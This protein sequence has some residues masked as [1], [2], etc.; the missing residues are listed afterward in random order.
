M[1]KKIIAAGLVC[2]MLVSSMTGCGFLVTNPNRN[3]LIHETDAPAIDDAKG[4]SGQ[5][6]SNL[7]TPAEEDQTD[8]S[9]RHLASAAYPEAILKVSSEE[10]FNSN[11]IFD[12]KAFEEDE[13]AWNEMWKEQRTLSEGLQDQMRDFYLT[14][15][16]FLQNNDGE[17][18]VCSPLSVYI[19]LAMLAE[20]AEG[21]T[22]AEI[23]QAIGA[24]SMEEARDLA[25]RLWR[26]NYVD[27]GE[28]LTDIASSLWLRKGLAVREDVLKT[29]AES[30]FAD[31][32]EGDPEDP[33]Y[34]KALQD[35]LNEKT[36]GLLQDAV[37][38]V[39]MDSE[40]LLSI[41]TTVYFRGKWQ[42]PF[43]PASNKMMTFH[44]TD[45][46][47]EAEF[48]YKIADDQYHFYDHFGAVALQ[49]S[50]NDIMWLILPDEGYTPEEIAQEQDFISCL[51]SNYD[52]NHTKFTMIHMS[53]PKFD[54][55]SDVDLCETLKDLGI[56]QAF[57]LEQADFTGLLAEDREEEPV[58]LSQVQHAARCMIDEEGCIATAFTLEMLAGA[59]M[60]D[61]EVDFTLDRPFLFAITSYTGAILFTGIVNQ[62]P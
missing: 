17:N 28:L 20:A 55:S 10:Y 50:G 16:V 52:E 30:Y 44:G 62:M 12:D 39:Q 49:M 35:W 13:K 58:Y 21:E 31:V 42:Y 54:V 24:D 53:V 11:G 43:D 60:P 47:K 1:L 2:V 29:V 9:V 41:V 59:A 34:T 3:E 61:G 18:R 51:S 14:S 25:V 56:Q 48:M 46:D 33:A 40:M 26:S 7:V 45:G 4:Y 32:Y 6:S 22:R 19:A 37:E 23:L 8:T 5:E 27:N 38:G 36:G 15:S 57:N